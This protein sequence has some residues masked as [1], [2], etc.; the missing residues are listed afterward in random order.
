MDDLFNNPRIISLRCASLTRI[1]K[2]KRICIHIFF[3][4]IYKYIVIKVIYFTII[5][6]VGK[7]FFNIFRKTTRKI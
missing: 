6:T 2:L 4:I 3:Y 5:I 1:V 7:L